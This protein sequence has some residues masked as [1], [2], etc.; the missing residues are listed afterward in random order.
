MELLGDV[1]GLQQALY[2]IGLMLISYFTK[3][4]F[5][6][7]LLR[8]LY[9]TKFDRGDLSKKSDLKSFKYFIR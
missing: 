3:R 6:S 7:Q 2:L 5:T 9:Q 4:L 1:G 8:E